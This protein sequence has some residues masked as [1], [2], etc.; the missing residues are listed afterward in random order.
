MNHVGKGRFISC[1][2]MG[3]KY[4]LAYEPLRAKTLYSNNIR[5]FF[6]YI[7]SN[8]LEKFWGAILTISPS[9]MAYD[10]CFH[11]LRYRAFEKGLWEAKLSAKKK[12]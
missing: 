5:I 12:I 7:I 8:F 6:L 3:E 11:R 1:K 9:K 10:F 4:S 2:N